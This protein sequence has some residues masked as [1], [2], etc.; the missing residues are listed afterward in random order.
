[1]LSDTDAAQSLGPSPIIYIIAGGWILIALLFIIIYFVYYLQP[2]EDGV[3]EI[4]VNDEENYTLGSTS[5]HTQHS[6][7]RHSIRQASS[8][9]WLSGSFS[10]WIGTSSQPPPTAYRN[11]LCPGGYY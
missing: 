2:S 3:P 7:T 4:K 11:H 10:R 6:V 5:F 1:V 8:S 9:G